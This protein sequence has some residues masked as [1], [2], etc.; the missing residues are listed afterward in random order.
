MSSI[1]SDPV[2]KRRTQ[3]EWLM[4]VHPP[5]CSTPH[6]TRI[7]VLSAW[8]NEPAVGEGKLDDDR[9]MD[10]F[11]RIFGFPQKL[12]TLTL[13][14]A[15]ALRLFRYILCLNSAKIRPIEWQKNDISK[16]GES[17]RGWHADFANIL[18]RARTLQTSK[19]FLAGSELF[20]D[21]IVMDLAVS[22]I[23]GQLSFINNF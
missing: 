19:G 15:E 22:K 21:Q 18:S 23:F 8:D 12:T 9:S 2:G 11:W 1:L 3:A 13:H 6:G 4:W 14:T 16:G 17:G 10:N 7:H 5:I 20:V